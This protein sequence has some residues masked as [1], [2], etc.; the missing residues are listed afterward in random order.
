MKLIKKG[1][2]GDIYISSW[3]NQAAIFKTRVK[4][5]YRNGVLDF[6]IRKHRTLME[7]VVISYV[8]YLGINSPLI[9][10]VDI[11]NC[12]IIMQYIN[13]IIVKDL[14]NVKI[15]DVCESIGSIV[16]TL[17]Q[18][19][20]MHGDLTT[21]NFIIFD[22]KI[23][24]ID[25]GLTSK[26]TKIIDYAVDLRLFKE[27]LNSAHTSIMEDAWHNFLIGYKETVSNYYQVIKQVKEIEARGR[28]NNNL[29]MQK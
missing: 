27:I 25:F 22:N 2:E 24:I 4:K 10:F 26:T 5:D 6:R 12:T 7:S 19:H 29:N 14:P 20:I 15:I 28:Y 1:A 18:N 16:G 13:G 21:S 8:K 9:Y 3:C 11:K 23:F 17:H